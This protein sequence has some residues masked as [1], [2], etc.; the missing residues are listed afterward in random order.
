MQ[1]ASNLRFVANFPLV[2]TICAK[3]RSR[4]PH[5]LRPSEPVGYETRR[6]SLVDGDFG[7]LI[8]HV[9]WLAAFSPST[10][11]LWWLTHQRCCGYPAYSKP[12]NHTHAPCTSA[13]GTSGIFGELS[14]DPASPATSCFTRGRVETKRWRDVRSPTLIKCC[15]FCF[16]IDIPKKPPE[17]F[18]RLWISDT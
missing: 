17:C 10:I 14:W 8:Y 16:T 15:P 4:H 9:N 2:N 1:V 11:S 7:T 18:G 5:L 6:T 13:L 3:D 12:A